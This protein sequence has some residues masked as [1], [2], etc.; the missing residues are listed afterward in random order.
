[1]LVEKGILIGYVE[2]GW[3]VVVGNDGGEF[4]CVVSTGCLVVTVVNC[5]RWQWVSS[6]DDGE[7]WWMTMVGWW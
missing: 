3:Q 2:C 6:G 4:W 1:M 7:L 5:G